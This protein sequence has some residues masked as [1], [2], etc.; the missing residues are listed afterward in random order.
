MKTLRTCEKGHSFFKS[1]DCP[2]CPV[3]EKEKSPGSGFLSLLSSPARRALLDEGIDTLQ[4]LS[5]YT[6]KEILKLHG[7]GRASLPVFR[8]SLRERGLSLK[9]AENKNR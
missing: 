5:A 6:E 1:S 4:K 8:E 7:V 2:A 3:C 9:P